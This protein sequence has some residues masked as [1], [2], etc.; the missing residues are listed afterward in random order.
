MKLF[1]VL[2]VQVLA[3]LTL[4]GVV[5]LLPQWVAPPYPDHYLVVCASMFALFWSYLFRLPKWW[6]WL[7]MLFPIV[8]WLGLQIELNPWW[9]LAAFIIVVLVFRN[10]FTGGVPL[11]LSNRTT[12]QA[13]NTLIDERFPER[14]DLS[15]IDIGCGVGGN[16]TA[17]SAHPSVSSVIGVET[18]PLVYAAAKLRTK[19][20]LKCSV[21]MQDL[22]Q[23]DLMSFDLVYAFLSPQPMSQ[24]WQKVQSE[25]RAG[26]VFVSNSFPVEDIEPTEVWELSDSR[27]TILYIYVIEKS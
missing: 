14:T 22:W 7:Q 10:A 17:W 1:K 6:W 4:A 12:Q 8:L 11:Y 2:L 24:L 3:I 25:M 21:L 19:K 9:A 26:S 18:A 5:Y 20:C 13:M 16:L 27:R 15:L 23:T